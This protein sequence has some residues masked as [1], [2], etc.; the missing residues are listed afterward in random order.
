MGVHGCAVLTGEVVQQVVSELRSV[1]D[2]VLRVLPPELQVVVARWTRSL[3][4]RRLCA[5][6]R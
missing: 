1:L 2:I 4:R 3:L 6:W 5:W